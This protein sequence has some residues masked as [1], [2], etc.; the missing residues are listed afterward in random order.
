[1]ASDR[2]RDAGLSHLDTSLKTI[3]QRRESSLSEGE[4]MIRGVDRPVT[5]ALLHTIEAALKVIRGAND[6]HDLGRAGC[7]ID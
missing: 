4:D 5:A 2:E 1:M 3:I 7:N 6:G